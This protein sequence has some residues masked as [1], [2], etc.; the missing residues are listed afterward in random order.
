MSAYARNNLGAAWAA[1]APPVVRQ[2]QA[3]QGRTARHDPAEHDLA[4]RDLAR[5]D[6]AGETPTA[7]PG[8][9]ARRKPAVPGG[10]ARG[11][12]AVLGGPAREQRR[13]ERLTCGGLSSRCPGR[14]RRR[15]RARC[16]WLR[17]P[18]GSRYGRWRRHRA[19]T[20][21]TR[22]RRARP[23]AR[24]RWPSRGRHPLIASSWPDPPGRN[25]RRRALPGTASAHDLGR[26]SRRPRRGTAGGW[27]PPRRTRPAPR[28]PR[29][30]GVRQ[31]R[32]SAIRPDCPAGPGPRSPIPR[33]CG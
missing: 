2:R 16:S 24:P 23:P 7:V 18:G 5:R 11:R 32:P 29:P 20:R 26:R 12:P 27:G 31:P 6:P 8:S 14:C 19:E 33:A 30:P 28:G 10:P 15:G 13:T 3:R 17:A 25:A 9:P 22:C 1:A 21:P 4:G